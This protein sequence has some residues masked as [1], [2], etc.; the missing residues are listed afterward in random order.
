M[1][2]EHARNP[3]RVMSGN[4]FCTESLHKMVCH[5]YAN[6]RKWPGPIHVQWVLVAKPPEP[7]GLRLDR[8]LSTSFAHAGSW[9]HFSM[10]RDQGLYL[11]ELEVVID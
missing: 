4:T 8:I 7:W 11:E 3:N 2:R 9:V 1:D 5:H 6:S 10:G